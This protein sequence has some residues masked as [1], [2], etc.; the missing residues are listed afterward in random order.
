MSGPLEPLDAAPL[1]KRAAVTFRFT[2]TSATSRRQPSRWVVQLWQSLT[3]CE[4][5][6]CSPPVPLTSSSDTQTPPREGNH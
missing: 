4:F 5:V 6:G 3:P 2:H 1:S